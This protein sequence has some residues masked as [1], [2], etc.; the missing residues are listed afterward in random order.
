VDG[1]T[2]TGKSNS[3]TFGSEANHI[4]MSAVRVTLVERE[5]TAIASM[6]NS[7]CLM[8]NEVYDLQGRRVSPQKKGVY[9]TNGKKVVYTNN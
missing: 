2:W 8:L 7:Q 5:T 6:H 9:I 1:Y 3:V 4:K